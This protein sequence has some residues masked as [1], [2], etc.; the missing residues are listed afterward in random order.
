[1]P[2]EKNISFLPLLFVCSFF[3]FTKAIFCLNYIMRLIKIF[4]SNTR[5]DFG[6]ST[7]NDITMSDESDVK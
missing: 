6:P 3:F 2:H 7:L 5:D 4:Y 1:M